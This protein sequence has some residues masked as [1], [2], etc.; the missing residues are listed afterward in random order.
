MAFCFKVS[1]GTCD[2]SLHYGVLLFRPIRFIVKGCVPRS[3][4]ES[5]SSLRSFVC[6]ARVCNRPVRVLALVSAISGIYRRMPKQCRPVFGG[7]EGLAISL[8][9]VEVIRRIE[10]ILPHKYLEDI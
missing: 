4:V 1:T 8:A 6:L 7:K 9:N 5:N 3:V 10:S 2:W